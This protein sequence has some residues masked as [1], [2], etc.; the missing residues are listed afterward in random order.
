M[1]RGGHNAY[2]HGLFKSRLAGGESRSG[3]GVMPFDGVADVIGEYGDV[4]HLAHVLFKCARR[5]GCSGESPAVHPFAVDEDGGV[6][7]L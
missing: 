1:V 4:L 6:H 5:S 7:L 2:F 3:I